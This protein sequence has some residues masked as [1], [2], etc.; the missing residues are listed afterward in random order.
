MAYN[1][2]VEKMK[3]G[4]IGSGVVGQATGKSLAG[5]NEVTFNDIK[6]ETLK[7]LYH[8]G[9]EVADN[10]PLLV[11]Q[12][13]MV[14]ICVNT[15]THQD[16]EQDLS[17]IDS[18]IPQLI[19]GIEYSKIMTTVIFRS[20]I[21]PT[22]IKQII[23]FMKKN[24]HGKKY[25]KDWNFFYNPEFLVAENSLDTMRYPDRVV[26][27]AE[28]DSNWY[29]MDEL[30]SYFDCPIIKTGIGEAS[31]IKYGS[32]CFLATKI[33]FFNELG[34]ISKNLSLNVKDIEYGI[35]L[36]KRIGTYGTKSGKPYGGTCFP[37]DIK[38]FCKNFSPQLI[39]KTMEVNEDG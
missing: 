28:E 12:S 20:T 25:Q 35:S 4:I 1:R 3:I 18:V 39:Q 13:D 31:M 15:P 24:I 36:D 5:F 32:N 34:S 22:K 7:Q 6:H 27:G 16:G 26:I 10:T 33:S 9:F 14:F 38:T 29:H 37:K 30:Y 11:E 8:D 21:I 17:Q 2:C 19:Q 23:D